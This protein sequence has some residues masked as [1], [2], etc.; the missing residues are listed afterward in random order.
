ML[1]KVGIKTQVHTEPKATFFKNAWT[2]SL[3]V[4]GFGSDTGEASSAFTA[5][6][7]SPIKEKNLGGVNRSGYANPKFDTLVDTALQTLDNKKREKLLQD[8]GRVA[9]DDTA[10]VAT[11][12]Q[13][14]VWAHR[15][16]LKYQARTDERTYGMYVSKK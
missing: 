10:F 14:N 15:P 2:Y 5:L 11:H 6:L 1:T 9:A 8:A 12:Y 4:L 7:H 3:V 16:D 13:V